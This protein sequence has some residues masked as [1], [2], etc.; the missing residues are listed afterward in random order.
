MA[1]TKSIP[2]SDVRCY[3]E[4]LKANLYYLAIMERRFRPIREL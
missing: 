3:Y 1:E 2:I 4:K